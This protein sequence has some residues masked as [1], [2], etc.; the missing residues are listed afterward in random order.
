LPTP[1]TMSGPWRSRWTRCS[2]ISSS[3]S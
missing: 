2:N 1:P 3:M